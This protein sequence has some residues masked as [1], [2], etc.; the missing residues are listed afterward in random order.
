MKE[1][2]SSNSNV[3]SMRQTCV[4]R[5]GMAAGS[6]RRVLALCF[7]VRNCYMF[8]ISK[9]REESDFR[10]VHDFGTCKKNA[11]AQCRLLT[12]LA[13]KR[14]W[15]L[16]NLAAKRVWPSEPIPLPLSF[17][18]PIAPPSLFLFFSFFSS[19][20]SFYFLSFSF[21]FLSFLPDN[22]PPFFPPPFPPSI[23]L[24]C[25]TF[26]FSFFFG[27]CVSVSSCVC[28]CVFGDSMCVD[29]W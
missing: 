20:S 17:P 11:A 25:S 24:S 5:S 2:V 9:C 27:V 16:T 14:V 21:S 1:L 18:H 10:S 3:I 26:S 6:K 7:S 29:Q 15:L 28:S 19:F 4:Q 12:N 23:F 22:P 13:A 8:L